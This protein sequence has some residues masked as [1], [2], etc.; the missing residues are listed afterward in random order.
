MSKINTEGY[1]LFELN[2]SRFGNPN[3]VNPTRS[4]G[5]PA[6]CVV[7]INGKPTKIAYH[8]EENTIYF[9]SKDWNGDVSWS[10]LSLPSIKFNSNLM[11][12]S[13]EF[14]G[15]LAEYLRHCSWKMLTHEQKANG[16]KNRNGDKIVKPIFREITTDDII[17]ETVEQKALRY[18]AGV[19]V[20]EMSDKE[21][22]SLA[23]S[24]NDSSIDDTKKVGF[25][26]G[27]GNILPQAQLRDAMCI[28]AEEYPEMFFE[29]YGDKNFEV[30]Q[31]LTEA[32]DEGLVSVNTSSR[33]LMYAKSGKEIPRSKAPLGVNPIEYFADR[34]GT[35]RSVTETYDY[36]HDMLKNGEGDVDGEKSLKPEELLQ[37]AMDVKAVVYKGPKIGYVFDNNV[38]SGILRKDDM[39]RG[40]IEND[41]FT[42]NDEQYGL[43]DYIDVRIRNNS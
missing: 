20:I 25:M 31:V 39:I 23:L 22:K 15:T 4:V 28:F 29:H 9:D 18:K 33:S 21:I 5:V 7:R 42:V 13:N 26:D 34:V 17:K 40:I 41:L 30:R 36:I 11:P 12:L 35:D 2:Q 27:Q 1:S 32:V 43:R 14:N 16:Q 3:G 19:T 8:P 37:R 6:K 10:Q 38:S 24:L